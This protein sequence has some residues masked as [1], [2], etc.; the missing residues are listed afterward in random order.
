MAMKYLEDSLTDRRR[1][2]IE[3]YKNHPLGNSL[4][5]S[6]SQLNVPV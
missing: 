4:V 5:E 6:I 2:N 1:V 3:A